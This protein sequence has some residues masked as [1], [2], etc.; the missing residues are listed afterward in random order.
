V[1]ASGHSNIFFIDMVITAMTHH[2]S[3]TATIVSTNY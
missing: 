1:N 3:L 2:I